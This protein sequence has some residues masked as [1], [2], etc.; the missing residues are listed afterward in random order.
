MGRKK[1][2]IGWLELLLAATIVAL[3]VQSIGL[4]I[5]GWRSRARA[6]VQV[7]ARYVGQVGDGADAVPFQFD[8]LLYLPSDCADGRPW[9]LVVYLHGAGE[10]GSDL[11][12]LRRGGLP[13]LVDRGRHF[14]FILVSPQCPADSRWEPDRI[15]KLIEHV[16]SS[17]RVDRSRVYLTGYSMGGFGTWSTACFDPD[18]FAAIV[19]LAAG[20]DVV[21]AGRLVD[22]P[23]WAF[24]G[25]K[26]QTVPLQ[27]S[28][29]MV[30]AVRK[31][32]GDVK[33]TVYPEHGHGICS[34]T[35]DNGR[36]FR[37]LLAQR[38]TQPPIRPSA[39]AKTVSLGQR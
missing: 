1:R 22:L 29:A 34:L 5:E 14:D 18:R 8:Y 35:Y 4:V 19:P 32:G 12:I 33:L 11:A 17:F 28:Q 10:R 26:D 36:L 2:R 30:D 23:I 6:G 13:G 31:S 20:G 38:R 3:V 24:H 15:V 39:V 27:A 25:A 7:P 37:W 21:Q 16:S 9:P